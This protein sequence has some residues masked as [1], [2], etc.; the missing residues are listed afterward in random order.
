MTVPPSGS[1]G[2]NDSVGV[3]VRVKVWPPESPRSDTSSE[4]AGS[5]RE[6]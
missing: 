1:L 4:V 2:R 3:V 5:G 6:L